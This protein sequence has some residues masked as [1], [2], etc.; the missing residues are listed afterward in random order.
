[1]H[2]LSEFLTS[3]TT[4]SPMWYLIDGFKK[5]VEEHA[6]ISFLIKNFLSLYC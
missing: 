4:G 2:F 5:K 1:M 3:T 6:G